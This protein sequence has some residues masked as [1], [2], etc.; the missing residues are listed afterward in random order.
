MQWA[1]FFNDMGTPTPE[2]IALSSGYSVPGNNALINVFSDI[3]EGSA[4]SPVTPTA[5]AA[6]AATVS[7]P[8]PVSVLPANTTEDI[9]N[10]DKDTLESAIILAE[11]FGSRPVSNSSSPHAEP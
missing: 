10:T 7:V 5:L 4:S 2:E 9:S 6:A 3:F 11:C 8:V 1:C